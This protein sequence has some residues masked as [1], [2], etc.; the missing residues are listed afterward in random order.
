MYTAIS[1]EPIGEFTGGGADPFEVDAIETDTQDLQTQIGT[2]GANLLDLGGM[3]TAMKAEI[4][5]EVVD[6][7][8]TDTI[9]EMAQGI[10]TTTPTFEEAIMYLYMALTKQVDVDTTSTDYKEFYNN[11]G[12]VIWKKTITDDGTVYSEAKGASGP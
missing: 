7:L 5:A 4:N 2:Q 9:A 3:S 10:P 6:V 11:A 12:T 8:K 1:R